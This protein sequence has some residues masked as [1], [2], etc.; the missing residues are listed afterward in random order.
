MISEH[1]IR[2][3]ASSC[4]CYTDVEGIVRQ[5]MTTV[6]EHRELIPKVESYTGARTNYQPQNLV[7]LNGTIR[8]SY[9]SAMYHTPI[10]IYLPPT[11][12]AQ[13]PECFIKPTHTMSIRRTKNVD[14][15]GKVYSPSLSS[16]RRDSYPQLTNCL[17]TLQSAFGEAP[18][19]VARTQETKP[20]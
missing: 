19:V 8:V 4:N 7:C 6:A 20:V 12:P 5:V 14:A 16:W 17:K 1:E 11:F 2:R 9:K 10:A 18:P 13:E 3:H 15:E